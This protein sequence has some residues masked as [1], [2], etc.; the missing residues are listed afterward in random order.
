MAEAA[1]CRPPAETAAE[2]RRAEIGRIAAERQRTEAL[3]RRLLGTGVSLAFGQ[4][5]ERVPI[6]GDWAYGWVE[7]YVTSYELLFRGLLAG[8]EAG[9]APWEAQVR[10]ATINEMRRVVFDHFDKLVVRPAELPQRLQAEWENAAAVAEAEWRAALQRS[11]AAVDRFVAEHCGPAAG[12]EAE[13]GWQPLRTRDGRLLEGAPPIRAL[14]RLEGLGDTNAIFLRSTRPFGARL[15]ILV[16]RVTEAG[17]A[18]ALGSAVG[19]ST[20]SGSAFGFFGAIGAVWTLDWAINHGDTLLHREEME[21]DM[22]ELV[23]DIEKEMLA[24]MVETL[25]DALA[26]SAEAEIARIDAIGR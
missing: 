7:S 16:A 9:A 3:A 11:R 13:R 5:R 10:T 21:R 15:A 26:T 19:A 8:V 18:F 1:S 14:Y 20:L 6:Y 23:T 2:F 22:R 17:S 24:G 12:P 4:V 25:S